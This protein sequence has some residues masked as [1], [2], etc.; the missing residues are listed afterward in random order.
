METGLTGCPPRDTFFALLLTH[1]FSPL[2]LTVAGL[3]RGTELAVSGCDFTIDRRDGPVWYTAHVSRS[4][5]AWQAKVLGLGFLLCFPTHCHP[6][7]IHLVPRH[8]L[9]GL[10]YFC[11]IDFPR[12]TTVRSQS[13]P[14]ST[15]QT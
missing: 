15:M 2:P 7:P 11:F 4:P 12:R 5:R 13:P 14:L 10:E 6:S 8:E 1:V 3:P 9:A